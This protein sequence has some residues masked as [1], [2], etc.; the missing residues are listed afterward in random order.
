MCNISGSRTDTFSS[1]PTSR[2][3]RNTQLVQ[4]DYQIQIVPVAIFLIVFGARMNILF[5]VEVK[6][7]FLNR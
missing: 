7:L 3:A 1:A 4:D 5:I 2:R 6:I